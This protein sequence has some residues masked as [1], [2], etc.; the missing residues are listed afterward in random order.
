M[1]RPISDLDVPL[2]RLQA[3]MHDLVVRQRL[4][5]LEQTRQTLPLDDPDRH[6]LDLDA[7]ARFADL[8]CQPQDGPQ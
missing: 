6:A 4:A 8:A 3:D 1:T 5:A 7:D 2:T